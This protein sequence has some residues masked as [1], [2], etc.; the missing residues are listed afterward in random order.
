ML[1]AGEIDENGVF[2]AKVLINFTYIY[3]YL[4]LFYFISVLLS[5]I[6]R[7]VVLVVFSRV[8]LVFCLILQYV[9]R[10]MT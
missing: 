10:P 8:V 3:L 2:G 7:H 1:V 4:T 5:I 6:F 9:W